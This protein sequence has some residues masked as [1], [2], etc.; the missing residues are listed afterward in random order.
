MSHGTL[1]QRIQSDVSGGK[2]K[3]TGSVESGTSASLVG[4]TIDPS[5]WKPGQA[6][7]VVACEMAKSIK[8]STQFKKHWLEKHQ[9]M[10]PIFQCTICGYRSKRKS[11]VYRH[12][13]TRHDCDGQVDFSSFFSCGFGLNQFFVDPFPL[14]QETVFRKMTDLHRT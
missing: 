2:R 12:L 14:A 9:Q 13:R 11:D 1:F 6:C 5:V 7:P 4:T 3:Q 10:V 8:D